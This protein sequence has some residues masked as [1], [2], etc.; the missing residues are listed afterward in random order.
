MTR[1]RRPHAAPRSADETIK[2]ER[3]N[4]QISKYKYS[5]NSGSAASNTK[6]H[7]V[8]QGLYKCILTTTTQLHRVHCFIRRSRQVRRLYQTCSSMFA[9][10]MLIILL[11]SSYIRTYYRRRL[12]LEEIVAPKRNRCE[13]RRILSRPFSNELILFY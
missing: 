10:Q 5:F 9:R 13:L 4:H 1:S 11:F 6:R 7:Q 2:T 12:T 3:K 8:S